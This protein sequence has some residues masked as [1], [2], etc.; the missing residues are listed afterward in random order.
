MTA[1]DWIALSSAAVAV[2]AFLV[3]ARALQLQQAA[4]ADDARQEFDDLVHKLGKALGQLAL[5]SAPSPTTGSAPVDL[6]QAMVEVT[7]LA[8]QA[9]DLLRTTDDVPRR[10]RLRALWKPSAPPP[11]ANWNEAVVLAY[12]FAQVWDTDR[13]SAYWEMAMRLCLD[14]K[15]RVG[16]SAQINTLRSTGCFY[17]NGNSEATLKQ[18]RDAFDQ[19]RD[20]LKPEINGVDLTHDQNFS[21]SFLQAQQED[22]LGYT[23]EAAKWLQNAC[24]AIDQVKATWRV[25]RAKDQMARFVVY[26]GDPDRF[27]AHGGVP[28]AISIPVAQLY[29]QNQMPASQQQALTIAWQQ[30]FMTAQQQMAAQHAVLPPLPEIPRAPAPTA[31]EDPR[32]TFPPL[33]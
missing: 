31:P 3:G 23:G 11:K 1:S 12:A 15:A 33:A 20:I 25:N 2:A 5:A 6:G 16:P 22:Q 26:R 10:G 30:G 29:N 21:T 32:V 28:G 9:N 13:A 18:A 7:T 19:A 14:P 17:Y 27:G 8:L 24:D 4:A